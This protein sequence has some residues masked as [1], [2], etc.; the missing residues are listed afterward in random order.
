ME[1]DTETD[2]TD[3]AAGVGESDVSR[4]AFVGVYGENHNEVLFRGLADRGVDVVDLGVT[5]RTIA[6]ARADARPPVLT[7]RAT[8]RWFRR[9]PDVAFLPLFL[10]TLAVHTVATLAVVSTNL[11]AVRDV[12]A[13]VVPHMGDTSVLAAKPLAVLLDVPLVYLSH[14]GMYFPLV[15]NQGVYDAGS[16]PGRTLYRADRLLHVLADRTVVFSAE[17]ARRFAATYDVPRSAY[18]VVYIAVA[19]SAFDRGEASDGDGP[20]VLYWGNFHS[21]HGVEAM[22]SAAAELPDYEF[23]F[24]GRSPKRER[25]VEHAETIGV[26][27]VSFPGFLELDDLARAIDG[28]AAVLGPVADNPQTEFTIGTKV[29][30]A[31]YL[32]KAIVLARTP[33]TTEVFSHEADAYL[34]TPGDPTSIARGV[35]RVVEDDEFR[36]DL[37]AG[38]HDVYESHFSSDR[39]AERL[40]EVCA[41]ADVSHSR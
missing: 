30:E 2:T 18:A 23:A 20:D 16:L 38:A 21:H 7:M 40:V 3:V 11:D 5:T 9:F 25:V 17:S 14:N 29:A 1:T 24:A 26:D 41:D 35:E 10:A 34:A 19:E 12:D 6:E 28:A 22:V 8:I 32:R 27:N 36:R 15:V 31:A 33:S 39:A 13:V 37:E 4:L